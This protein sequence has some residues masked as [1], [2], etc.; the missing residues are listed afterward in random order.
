MKLNKIYLLIGILFFTSAIINAQVENVPI[1]HQVYNFL[2]EMKVKGVINSIHDDNPSMSAEEVLT[3]LKL[4]NE[5]SK[6]LSSTESAILKKYIDEFN[7][8][9]QNKLNTFEL[10]G[11]GEQYSNSFSEFWSEKK[12]YS[13]IYKDSAL[14]FFFN[15]LGNIKYGHRFS[16]S[17][18][19]AEMYDIG[20][21]FKGT[22][23]NKFG[24]SLSVQKGGV[25]G[26]ESF[27]TKID[28]RLL[29][30][31]KFVEA[32][33]NIGNYDFA[34]GYLKYQTQPVENM[35]IDFQIGREKTKMGYGYGS[36]LI[37]SGDHALLDFVRFNFNY[38]VFSFTSMHASTV[39]RFIWEREQNYTKQI[40]INRF[41]LNFEDVLEFGLGESIIYSGRGIDLAYLNPFIFYKFVEMSLQD[42]D[43]G[44]VWLDLQTHAFNDLEFQFTFFL[45]ENILSHLE[46]LNLFT[47]KTAYQIG[48]FWYSPL[49]VDDLSLITEYTRIRPYVYAH[50]NFRNTYTSWDQVL[51]HRIGPNADEILVK[52]NYNY[53]EKMT[54]YG[55]FRAIRSGENIYTPDGNLHYNAGGDP[56]VI[57]RD[58]IEARYI[59]F[60]SGERI[61]HQMISAGIRFEPIRDF[62]FDFNYQ[63]IRENKIT[64][65]LKNKNSLFTVKL[66]FEM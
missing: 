6:E 11:S 10:F 66:S 30:N 17:A 34:E 18:T 23:L 27:A 64:R 21:R 12:K 58:G 28:P 13:I 61:N 9:N 4:I 33:E 20:I 63:Y 49:G 1:D 26:S 56:F 41:K 29:Y 25:S 38:G 54:L 37:L 36:K 42:R 39:G 40:A 32:V 60:L 62:I 31:F 8:Y 51:G 57:H 59:D 44:A 5:K 24:Y 2:K 22:L 3:K 16:P 14:T 35:N 43:N 46:E 53:N 7:I 52:A 65:E 48:A 50:Y 15:I 55:E 47:N 45:D 19:D